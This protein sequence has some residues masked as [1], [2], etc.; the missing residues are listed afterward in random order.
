[1]SIQ[2][3]PRIMPIELRVASPVSEKIGGETK[4][5]SPL[6]VADMGSL[7]QEAEK[8]ATARAH[9]KLEFLKALDLNT[10]ENRKELAQELFRLLDSG[11]VHAMW[12]LD[13]E[14]TAY[15]L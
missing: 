7:R 11:A 12:M 10:A 15:S 13:F 14:G 3:K 4:L 1:M 6:T 2:A 5:F 9:K 8:F